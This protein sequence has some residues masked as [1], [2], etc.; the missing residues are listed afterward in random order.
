[1]DLN[2]GF[3]KLNVC[4]CKCHKDGVGIIKEDNCCDSKNKKFF[5]EDN[6]LDGDRL[7]LIYIEKSHPELNN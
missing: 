3:V 6:T 4:E 7:K 2:F 1:M 5:N